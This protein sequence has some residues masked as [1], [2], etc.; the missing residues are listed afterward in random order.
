MDALNISP[1]QLRQQAADAEA[2]AASIATAQSAVSSVTLDYGAFGVMCSFLVMPALG[3]TLVAGSLMG[4]A[5]SMLER[6]A[7]ALRDAA[8]DFVACDETC[9]QQLAQVDTGYDPAGRYR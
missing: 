2:G 6:E 5:K 4:E 9:E 3:V 1:E 8:D 7:Q